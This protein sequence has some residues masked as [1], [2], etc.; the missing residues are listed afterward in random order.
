MKSIQI[1]LIVLLFA[2]GINALSQDKMEPYYISKIIE[3][4][5]EDVTEKVKIAFKEQKFGV[6]ME[7]D[8]DE[9]ISEKLED[10]EM[11]PYKI[12]GVCN[13]VYAYKTLQ[14][15]ENIGVFLPCKVLIKQ[16]DNNQVE[17]VA[18]NPSVLMK[19]MGNDKLTSI[20]DDV[21]VKFKQAL[22]NI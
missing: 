6:V 19:M 16:K 1:T 5:F 21:T 22:D 20:A 9:K 2:I 10:V 14:E 12:L 4:S 15:E 18:V 17:V 3:G 8:M 7:I 13:P 11:K